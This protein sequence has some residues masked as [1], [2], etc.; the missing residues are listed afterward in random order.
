VDGTRTDHKLVMN[1]VWVRPH[2]ATNINHTT[3]VASFI[4][5]TCMIVGSAAAEGA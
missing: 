2:K 5:E 4:D 1:A 3:T